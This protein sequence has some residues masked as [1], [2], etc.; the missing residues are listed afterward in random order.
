MEIKNIK[1][2]NKLGKDIDKE[3][4]D[5][6]LDGVLTNNLRIVDI[7][8]DLLKLL[9]LGD[10]Y[11]ASN[12]DPIKIKEYLLK[13]LDSYGENIKE[14]RINLVVDIPEEFE[15]KMEESKVK[16]IFV[17]L[18]DNAIKYSNEGGE[19]KVKVRKE[20][21][22]VKFEISDKGIGIPA[23]EQIQVFDRFFRASNSYLKASVGSGLGLIIAKVIIEGH[24]GE[25][26]FESKEKE[27]T[28]FWFTL[29]INEK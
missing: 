15:I 29:P 2:K 14:K 1:Q 21:N 22:F 24:G 13:I 11:F 12:L 9:E 16:E 6:I 26:G 23:K 27:G 10:N 5:S 28:T 25:I 20:V 4:I 3:E 18:I 7:T 8:N 19:I 17:N